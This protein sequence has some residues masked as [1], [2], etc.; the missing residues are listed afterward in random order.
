MRLKSDV[1]IRRIKRIINKKTSK[2]YEIVNFLMGLISKIF[3]LK[4]RQSPSISLNYNC[5]NSKNKRT[6]Q[7]EQ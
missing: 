3:R 2:S 6:K 4:D 7:I 1:M 5:K